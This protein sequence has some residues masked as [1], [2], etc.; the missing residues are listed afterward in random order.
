MKRRCY[1]KHEA[2]YKHYG[3]RGIEICDEWLNSF[4]A[5]EEWA[6][7]NGYD[8]DA[9]TRECTI[10]RIDVNGNYEPSNCRWI[11][12][13]EQMKNTTRSKQNREREVGMLESD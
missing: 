3:N 12:M 1:N 9:P 2:S 6:F 13:D 5:F 4:N 11:P 8:P 7:A 10:D